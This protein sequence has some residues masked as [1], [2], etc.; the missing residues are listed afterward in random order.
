MPLF[1][2]TLDSKPDIQFL[3]DG[4]RI[5]LSGMIFDIVDEVGAIGPKTGDR[6]DLLVDTVR[7]WTKIARVQ[8][9]EPNGKKKEQISVQ[10]PGFESFLG[11]S[12]KLHDKEKVEKSSGSGPE[13]RSSSEPG[14]LKSIKQR[15]SAFCATL[16]AGYMRLED[17]QEQ[18][19]KFV[20]EMSLAASLNFAEDTVG[21]I[22]RFHEGNLRDLGGFMTEELRHEL[23]GLSHKKQK[24]VRDQLNADLEELEAKRPST[25][26]VQRRMRVLTNRRFARSSKGYYTLVPARAQVG[27]TIALIKGA[28][29]P[30]II[31]KVDSGWVLLGEAYVHGIMGGEAFEEDQCQK[32]TII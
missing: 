14:Y 16:T 23:S 13:R 22:Q 24:S 6:P 29:L 32:F 7:A 8:G 26:L 28:D 20:Y 9:D 4:K 31:R 10:K 25:E 2:T 18:V 3:E 19:M 17:A 30:L 21:L 5:A 12:L 27:D 11:A 1:H 15:D